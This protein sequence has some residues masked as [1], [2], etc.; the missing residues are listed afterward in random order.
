MV[1][2]DAP[3]HIGRLPPNM[4]QPRPGIEPFSRPES[5]H[6]SG[7]RASRWAVCPSEF[8]RWYDGPTPPLGW[9]IQS[10]GSHGRAARKERWLRRGGSGRS[11]M[12]TVLIDFLTETRTQF[13]S[14]RLPTPTFHQSSQF[15]TRKP[16]TL[17]KSLRL[18]DNRSAWLTSAVAAIFRSLEPM[19]SFRRQRS[20][21]C[22]AAGSS[23][24]TISNSW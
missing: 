20:S 19:R 6:R 11:L 2:G 17:S 24:G 16:G 23:N 4:C 15:S 5:S 3:A 8:T 13:V 18:A 9:L 1:S 22:R 21:N 7:C 12:H 14:P 10:R